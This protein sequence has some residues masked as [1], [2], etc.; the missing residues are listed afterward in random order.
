MKFHNKLFVIEAWRWLFN[1]AQEDDPVWI[2]DA[3]GIW[4]GI[5]GIV[6][7][8]EHPQGPRICIATDSGVMIVEPGDWIVRYEDGKLYSCKSDI[9]DKTYEE[10]K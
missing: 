1:L 2:K 10:C 3:L 7:E 6:F 9:F 5:G 8:P 4:P